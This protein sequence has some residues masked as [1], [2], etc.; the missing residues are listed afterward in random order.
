VRAYV[1][2][3]RVH[4]SQRS[5]TSFLFGPTPNAFDDIT[6]LRPLSEAILN[7]NLIDMDLFTYYATYRIWIC[8]LCGFTL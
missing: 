2:I 7:P 8:S 5:L 1:L 3:P 4:N 6:S